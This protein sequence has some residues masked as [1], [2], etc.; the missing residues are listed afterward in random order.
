MKELTLSP[1]R[2]EALASGKG[3]DRVAV[4]N[5]LCFIGD[6]R[7]AAYE[8]MRAD[9]RSYGWNAK[10]VEAICKGVSEATVQS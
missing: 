8:N 9:A 10:T 1:T 7:H 6:D 2:I 4:E 5:F 3:V